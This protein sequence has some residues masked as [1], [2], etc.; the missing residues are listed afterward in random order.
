MPNASAMKLANKDDEKPDAETQCLWIE[1]HLQEDLGDQ[2][3]D[4]GMDTRA[5]EEAF[6]AEPMPAPDPPPPPPPVAAG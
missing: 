1:D 2:A 5:D 3:N 4:L 6:D